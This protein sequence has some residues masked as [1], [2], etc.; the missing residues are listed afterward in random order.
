MGENENILDD[1]KKTLRLVIDQFK[2]IPPDTVPHEWA[3]MK[4]RGSATYTLSSVSI[5]KTYGATVMQI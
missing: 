5:L 2:V 3:E 1:I 4:A